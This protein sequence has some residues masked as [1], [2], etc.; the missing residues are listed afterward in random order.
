MGPGFRPPSGEAACSPTSSSSPA[1]LRSTCRSAGKWAACCP[2]EAV[3]W[4][5]G[6]TVPSPAPRGRAT[7]LS[8]AGSQHKLAGSPL[9]VLLQPCCASLAATAQPR[10]PKHGAANCSWPGSA[11]GH[12]RAMCAQARSQPSF[13]A[14]LGRAT[15]SLTCCVETR[16]SHG[17]C[18]TGPLA[19]ACSW[20]MWQGVAC[21]SAVAAA[22]A[23]GS[24]PGTQLP[25]PAPLSPPTSAGDPSW[26]AT[27][28]EVLVGLTWL[29]SA[30]GAGV[31]ARRALLRVPAVP[32]RC[33][34]VP[35]LSTLPRNSTGTGAG[36]Q[37]RPQFTSRGLISYVHRCPQC[38][39]C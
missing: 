33:R 11:R 27:A 5:P 22:A 17:V 26:L 39:R 37:R 4:P 21:L 9:G 23:A 7:G 2:G 6:P 10:R 19:S 15:T 12:R 3:S 13:P 14:P 29:V 30:T 28:S 18:T 24:S 38:S 32:A 25:R 35:E 36:R 31:T 8:Q 20:R 16:A 1:P 34:T